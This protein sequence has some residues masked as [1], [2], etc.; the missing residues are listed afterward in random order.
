MFA[1]LARHRAFLR[2]D[3]PKIDHG[4][5]RRKGD[6]CLSSRVSI[7]CD[8]NL[9]A[10]TPPE[11]IGLVLDVASRVQPLVLV[12]ESTCADSPVRSRRAALFPRPNGRSNR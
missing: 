8:L 3:Q 6:R 11:M 5:P 4:A 1:V 2:V 12:D 9:A 10:T 7:S